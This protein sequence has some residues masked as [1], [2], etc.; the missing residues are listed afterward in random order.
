MEPK[1]IA[2]GSVVTLFVVG[3]LA[4][5][6]VVATSDTGSPAGD[7]H[8]HEHVSTE[9]QTSTTSEERRV[10]TEEAPEDVTN[11]LPAAKALKQNLSESEQFSD[12]NVSI[13]RDGRLV[14]KHTS[15]ADSAAALKEEMGEIAQRYAAV[16]GEHNESG[17]LIVLSNGVKLTVQTDAAIAYDDGKLKEDAYSETFHWSTYGSGS[18][19]D[20]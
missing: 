20:A 3:L 12:A 7:G 10:S 4:G 18:E 14:V 11:S 16:V 5:G 15:N 9:R 19:S 17:N 2:L 6:L 8:E 13:T 1:A